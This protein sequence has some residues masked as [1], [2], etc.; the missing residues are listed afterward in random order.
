[1]AGSV[2][3]LLL[4]ICSAVISALGAPGPRCEFDIGAQAAE[5]QLR[6]YALDNLTLL[7]QFVSDGRPVKVQVVNG[8]LDKFHL[9]SARANRNEQT[10]RCD[11][12]DDADDG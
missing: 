9:F 6:C 12:D 8:P 2:A 1:M 11:D 7:E 4:L 5:K 10:S 3:A